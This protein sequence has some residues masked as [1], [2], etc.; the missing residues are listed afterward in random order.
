MKKLNIN[1]IKS[2]QLNILDEVHNFCIN[3]GI[4]YS[5]AFGS[6]LGAVRHNGYIPWDDDIDIMMLRKDYERFIRIFDST[7]CKINS[8]ESDNNC[9][10]PFTKVFDE[11]TT[12]IEDTKFHCELGVNIDVFPIDN[13]PDNILQ[14]WKMYK[15]KNVW[16]IIYTLKIVPFSLERNLFKNIILLFGHLFFSIVPLSYIIKNIILLGKKY[17]HTTT[18][19]RAIFVPVDNKKKWIQSSELFDDII[20]LPFENKRF[21]CVKNYHLYLTALYGDYNTF[22]PI[23]ERVTHHGFE[24]FWKI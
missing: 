12:L 11:R 1:D 20:L 18:K 16:N 5:L 19:D 21:Y 8:F 4:K 3:N 24:A 22:P 15:I 17:E 2:I 23:E 14:R 10:I 6:L 7:F 13:I 9:Y